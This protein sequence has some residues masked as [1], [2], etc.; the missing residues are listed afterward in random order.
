MNSS[1]FFRQHNI[2]NKLKIHHFNDFTIC[3]LYIKF[4]CYF[5]VSGHKDNSAKSMPN[6]PVPVF[7]YKNLQ[8]FIGY[9]NEEN[10]FIFI[11]FSLFYENFINRLLCSIFF[12]LYKYKLINLCAFQKTCLGR[13]LWFRP[14]VKKNHSR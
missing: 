10:D 14:Q 11:V 8:T 6:T 9:E 7:S 2:T 12:N 4:F 13:F 5:I 1:V 3:K